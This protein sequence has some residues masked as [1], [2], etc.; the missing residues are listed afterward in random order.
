MTADI[1]QTENVTLYRGDTAILQDL[2]LSVRQ[3]E[4]VLIRGKSGAG[5]TT[6]FRVLGLLEPPTDGT[7]VV[8]GVDATAAGERERA[9]LRREK[10]GVVF[11]DFQLVPDLTAWENA[12]LPQEHESGGAGRDWM[13]TVFEQL[14][15]TELA[16][17]YPSTLSGGERQRVAIARAV[18]N[19]PVIILADE[20]T[21]QLDPETTERVLDLL[22][23]MRATA[24]A[25]LVVVSHDER[26]VEP[27]PA[28]YEFVDGGLNRRY[29]HAEQGHTEPAGADE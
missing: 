13:E 5:K 28:G 9:R 3:N 18:A 4:R 12:R 25:A 19:K 21:G 22:F 23:E 29:T 20:P 7:V 17:R 15:I 2:S 24:G 11:Q 1:L 26:L 6:L 8:D 10:L 14:E 27:F 16:D